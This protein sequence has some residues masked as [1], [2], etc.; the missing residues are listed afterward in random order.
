MNKIALSVSTMFLS[1]CTAS[2]I[3]TPA[4]KNGWLFLAVISGLVTIVGAIIM[5]V[6]KKGQ[7]DRHLLAMTVIAAAALVIAV[8]FL[9]AICA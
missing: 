6:A 3:C 7:H 2:N 5:L 8:I 1:G 9:L 4:H